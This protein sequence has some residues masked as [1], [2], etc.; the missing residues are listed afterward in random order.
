MEH[1]AVASYSN[2]ANKICKIYS[3]LQILLSAVSNLCST[4][5]HSKVALMVCYRLQSAFCLSSALHSAECGLF[6]QQ[7]QPVRWW[8][9]GPASRDRSSSLQC[10]QQEV[11]IAAA[12]QG[13]ASSSSASNAR[14]SSSS[15]G[16]AMQHRQPGE[17]TP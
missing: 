10:Q 4:I 15:S 3:S 11:A 7:Q 1:V 14:S 13:S 12:V 17:S 8:A 9:G 5:K 2:A 16:Q 6:R